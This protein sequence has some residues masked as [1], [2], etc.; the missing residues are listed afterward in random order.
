SPCR[1]IRLADRRPRRAGYGAAHCWAAPVGRPVEGPDWN[2]WRNPS[3]QG[4]ASVTSCSPELVPTIAFVRVLWCSLGCACT[5]KQPGPL[6]APEFLV[7]HIGF[8]PG[9]F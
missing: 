7:V 3:P 8:W 2:A 6:I 5:A 1:P 4:F 9:F